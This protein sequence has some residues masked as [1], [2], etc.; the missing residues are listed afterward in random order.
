[1]PNPQFKKSRKY[2]VR[3]ADFTMT[4]CVLA[5]TVI[6]EIWRKNA[7]TH[8]PLKVELSVKMNQA[9]ITPFTA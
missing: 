7:A 3:M 5:A 4:F 8:Q 9:I 1:M 6:N 2:T